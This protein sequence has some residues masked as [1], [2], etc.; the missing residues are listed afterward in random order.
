MLYIE[1]RCFITISS[2]FNS[3][4]C[5]MW[6]ILVP[7]RLFYWQKIGLTFDLVKNWPWNA[8]NTSF[9]QGRSPNPPFQWRRTISMTT[10]IHGQ[11]YTIPPP[12]IHTSL[13]QHRSNG[14]AVF[15]QATTVELLP[16]FVRGRLLY[17]LPEK[18]EYLNLLNC[19]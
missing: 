9:F 13:Q 5:Y 15:L 2:L 10:T 16:T 17:S 19:L 8:L 6:Y 4:R 1:G 7:C 3:S 11:C 18:A 12:C 14:I